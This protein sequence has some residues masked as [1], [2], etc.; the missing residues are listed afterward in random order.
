MKRDMD[1]IREMLLKLEGEPL[2]GNL[3]QVDPVQLGIRDRSP[4]ELS[5]HLLLL[6]DGGLVDGERDQSGGF[7]LQ[8]LTWRGH[9]F[10]DDIR[11]PEIWRKTKD[12]AGKVGRASLDFMWEI[13]KA[14]GKH[15]AKE[16]LGLDVT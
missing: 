12:G 7:V 10:L 8:K 2:D 6:I 4:E 14:Y 9:E 15:L 1:L 11:S 13:A 16:K 3:Y 5:Y